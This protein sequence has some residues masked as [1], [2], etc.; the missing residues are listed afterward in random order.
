MISYL[1]VFSG[2]ILREELGQGLG[3]ISCV[4]DNGYVLKEGETVIGL[5]EPGEGYLYLSL[6]LLKD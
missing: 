3:L 5:V 2:A 4:P 1:V 6:I